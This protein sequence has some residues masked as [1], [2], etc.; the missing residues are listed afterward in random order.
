MRTIPLGTVVPAAFIAFGFV[1][2]GHLGD[3]LRQDWWAAV[4]AFIV[5]AMTVALPGRFPL[6]ASIV[7]VVAFAGLST[8]TAFDAIALMCCV[9]AGFFF[10][11]FVRSLLFQRKRRKSD[12][13]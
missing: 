8:V 9:L 5:G 2:Q 4:L 13:A 12:P 7:A 3:A 6:L 10:G 1:Q 11:L